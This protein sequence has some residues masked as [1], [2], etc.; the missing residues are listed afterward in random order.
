MRKFFIDLDWLIILPILTLSIMS[1]ITMLSFN[2]NN[3][4]MV[5]QALIIRHIIYIVIGFMISIMISKIDYRSFS[6]LVQP[7]FFFILGLLIIVLVW[8]NRV[9]GAK[10]W[11]SIG[12]INLQ[13]AEFAKAVVVIIIA[14]YLSRYHY[15]I[16]NFGYII[17]S[18]I[19]ILII[20]SLILLQPDFGTAT[21][22]ILIW[23]GMLIFGG[24]RLKHI[25]ILGLIG[26]FTSIILW[27]WVFKEY[28]KDRI[29][30]FLDP[31]SDPLGS[32]YNSIQSI[33]AVV[34][35]GIIGTKEQNIIV[36]EV[37]TDFIFS[38]FIQQWGFVGVS[39][40]FI[41]LL[42][43]IF[44]LLYIAINSQDSFSKMIVLGVVLCIMIQLII[45]VGMN[46]GVMPITGV[47]L[48]FMSY[49]GSSM[50]LYWILIGFILSIQSHKLSE[51]NIFVKDNE[52]IF[53]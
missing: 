18:L 45:N 25:L 8:G 17:L 2:I 51:T 12:V 16:N 6:T 47:P 49:G 53:G 48:P 31:T 42:L 34:S 35:G 11:L 15:K 9:N 50:L 36:P 1:V 38:G 24:V 14:H 39:I 26:L 3:I 10:S 41:I 22:L 33:K 28:Q 23:L 44:R 46:L 43:I 13:P 4:S 30:T 29:L 37:H 32:G 52:D 27:T 21:I 5:T 7:L 19:P 20:V 40:Y